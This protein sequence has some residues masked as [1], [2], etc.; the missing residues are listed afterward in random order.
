[1]K[2]LSTV[3]QINS[4][5]KSGKRVI[6]KFYA[7]WCGACLSIKN[8]YIKMS[9]TYNKVIFYEVNVD[10]VKNIGDAFGIENIPDIR[11]YEGGKMKARMLG[12]NLK[13]FEHNLK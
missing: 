5:I 8:E 1:M 4:A 6:I 9:N 2:V 7:K 13:S 3:S 10:S 12:T 11:Y